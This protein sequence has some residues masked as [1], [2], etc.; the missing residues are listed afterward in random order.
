MRSRSGL[1]EHLGLLVGEEQP[2]AVLLLERAP[3]LVDVDPQPRHDAAQ[4][5]ALPGARPR[6]D[7]A[8]ADAQR[9]VRH[10]ESSLTSCSSP[11]PWQ[12]G[13]AP[14]A[15]FGENASASSRD[16]PSRVGAG[17]RVEHPHQVRQRRQRPD[18]R[19]G[20]RGPAPLLERHG[21]RQ[22]GDLL[23]VRG[24]R[25]AAAADARR[26]PPTRSSDAAPRRRA[27]RRPARTCRSRTR[28]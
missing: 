13:Q 28:R 2:V 21:R 24:T 16:A 7:R 25:P 11:S 17:A 18:T 6:G 9:G 10:H 8:L 20:A 22:P 15:V 27:C 4:V 1:I 3:G 19:A 14:A 12:R 26:A 23:H 5:G